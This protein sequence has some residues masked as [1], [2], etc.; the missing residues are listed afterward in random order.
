MNIGVIVARY[1]VDILPVQR[2]RHY[3]AQQFTLFIS[4]LQGKLYDILMDFEEVS[5]GSPVLDM[6]I[7]LE[8]QRFP[9]CIVWTPLPIL[10]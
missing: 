8:R 3:P 2:W 9:F 10:T 6:T 4:V 1:F 7:D 5:V